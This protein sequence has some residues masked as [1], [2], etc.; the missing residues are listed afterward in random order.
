MRRSPHQGSNQHPFWTASNLFR[1]YEFLVSSFLYS[2]IECAFHF[3]YTYNLVLNLL[4]SQT[5]SESA[6]LLTHSMVSYSRGLCPSGFS[7]S[8]S[9][10]PTITDI[11]GLSC[12]LFWAA[13]FN[14]I[15]F[16]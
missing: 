11:S 9:L 10:C 8:K 3:I 16:S 6:I 4:V 1:S 5:A 15:V 12:S 2:F 14:A 13:G 7:K